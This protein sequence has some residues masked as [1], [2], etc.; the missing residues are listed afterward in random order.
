MMTHKYNKQVFALLVS[1]AL[2]SACSVTKTY[3]TPK[4]KTDGLYRGQNVTDSATMASRPWQKLFT[5]DKLK[6]LIQKGL[7]QNVNLKMRYKTFC[8]LRLLYSKLN[9]LFYQL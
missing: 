5:D 4:V 2:F 3:E 7:D 9:W 8:R 1:A 6:V